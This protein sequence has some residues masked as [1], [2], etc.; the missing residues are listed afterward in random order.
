MPGFFELLAFGVI[1]AFW[2]AVGVAVVKILRK[3]YPG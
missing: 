2:I 3:P 1:L